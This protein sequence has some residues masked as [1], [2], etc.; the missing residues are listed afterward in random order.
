M[1]PDRPG[2][3]AGGLRVSP[4]TPEAF[5]PYGRLIRMPSSPATASG[6]GWDWWGEVEPLEAGD[7][8]YTL[9]FLSLRP[10]GMSFN[11]AERHMR[12]RE[13]IVPMG[14]KCLIYVAVPSRP[15]DADRPSPDGFSVFGLGPGEAVLLEKGIW[16]GAPLAVDRPLSVLIALLECTGAEDTQAV[17]LQE[18]TVTR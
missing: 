3:G 16:H 10:A 1:A 13:L 11:W 14:G 2:A 5:A 17:G 6:P 8:P 9:G 4:L 7:R 15:V 18:L 12:S